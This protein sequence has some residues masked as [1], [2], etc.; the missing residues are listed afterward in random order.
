[1]KTLLIR[2]KPGRK[3]GAESELTQVT[4]A[5]AEGTLRAARALLLQA[6]DEAMRRTAQGEPI[7]GDAKAALRLAATHA[8]WSSAE[9]VDVAYHL[10]GGAALYDKSPLQRHFRDVH[11]MTQHIMVAEPT[12]KPIGRILL[13]R[14]TQTAQL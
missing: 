7:D 11:T 9:V 12:L 8:A 14:P 1:V 6:L 4:F 3:S 2:K 13:G 10:G 5:R